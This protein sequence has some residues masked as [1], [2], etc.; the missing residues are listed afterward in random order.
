M[1]NVVAQAM[2]LN[3]EQAA[4]GKT[5]ENENIKEKDLVR[6]ELREI[7]IVQIQTYKN[8][9]ALGRIEQTLQDMKRSE[10][11]GSSA[12][13]PAPIISSDED[14]SSSLVQF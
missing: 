11:L 3:R 10:M 7:A 5:K 6:D 4:I 14:R 9:L 8:N 1:K 13:A 12:K 2:T